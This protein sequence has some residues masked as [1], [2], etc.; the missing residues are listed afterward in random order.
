VATQTIETWWPA[1][2]LFTFFGQVMVA[3]VVGAVGAWFVV[4]TA[5]ERRALTASVTLPRF[6]SAP[7]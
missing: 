2:N 7:R 3:L 1:S 5:S 6:V 4:L